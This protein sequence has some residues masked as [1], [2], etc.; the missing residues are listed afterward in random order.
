MG[1][2]RC[3]VF[4]DAGPVANKTKA[5]RP[6]EKRKTVVAG[7]GEEGGLGTST[8][9]AGTEGRKM[10]R[11][12]D[13]ILPSA[14]E[15]A[16]HNLSRIPFRNWCPYCIRGRGKEM[17]HT[18]V[19]T[20]ERGLDEFHMD[21]CFPGDEFGFKL[22]IL[23][24]VERYTGMKASIVV[25]RKGSTGNFAARRA[26]ELINECGNKDVD[27]IVKTDQEPSIEYLVDDI[28]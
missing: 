2:K 23:V 14:E 12:I 15:I 24:V 7:V 17:N 8:D 16:D 4:S 27:I 5:V 21:Y 26:I 11:M 25:P 20:D 28:S 22:V 1:S 19:N 3:F 10:K 6:I 9:E 18:R 13:P